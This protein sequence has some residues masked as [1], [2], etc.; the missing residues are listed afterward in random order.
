M[1]CVEYNEKAFDHPYLLRR[2]MIN[3]III[4][5][6]RTPTVTIP[7]NMGFLVSVELFVDPHEA[8]VMDG[9]FVVGRLIVLA[10]NIVVG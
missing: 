7:Y 2:Q 1:L 8:V 5:S 4:I 9:F 3:K 6:C 10:G